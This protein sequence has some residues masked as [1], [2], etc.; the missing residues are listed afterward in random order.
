MFLFYVFPVNEGLIVM[1]LLNLS[2]SLSRTLTKKN[3]LKNY[4]LPVMSCRLSGLDASPNMQNLMKTHSKFF[5][6]LILT[7][8]DLDFCFW[9]IT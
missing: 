4:R 7:N 6:G 2:K 5:H 1:S 3:S 9:I 8:F